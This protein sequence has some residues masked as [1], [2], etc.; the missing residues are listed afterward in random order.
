MVTAPIFYAFY[1][2]IY[3]KSK[4]F[5]AMKFYNDAS[6]QN[7]YVYGLSAVTASTC[8]DI[9]TNPLW[10]VR[11]RYMTEYIH[12]KK[13]VYDSFNVFKEIYKI[14]KAEG[15]FALY[16]GF[17]ASFMSCHHSIIQFSIYETLK[18]KSAAHL[19]KEVNQ[20][21]PHYIMLSS[22]TAKSKK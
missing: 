15:F 4:K 18:K 5:Y 10:V 3:E 19:N 9:I 22:V 1:F 14:Y 12:S 21:P 20:L 11:V 8:C 2:P 7:I 6:I 13:G 17:L 16:R